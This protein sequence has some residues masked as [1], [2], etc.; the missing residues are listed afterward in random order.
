MM[1]TR[2]PVSRA[3]GT[4]FSMVALIHLKTVLLAQ[5]PSAS[6]ST[7]VIA[8]PGLLRSCRNAKRTS[9]KSPAMVTPPKKLFSRLRE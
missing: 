1:V 9:W 2:L 8:N 3:P 4:G 7:A 5:M 6:I